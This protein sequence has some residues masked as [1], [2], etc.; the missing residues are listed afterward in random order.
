MDNFYMFFVM[1]CAK[2]SQRDDMS[3]LFITFIL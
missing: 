1:L 2:L 3:V